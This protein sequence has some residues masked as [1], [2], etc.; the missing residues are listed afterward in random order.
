[1]HRKII[2]AKRYYTEHAGVMDVEVRQERTLARCAPG[3]DGERCRR[4]GYGA[5]ACDR[6]RGPADREGVNYRGK[7]LLRASTKG[8]VLASQTSN[9][10]LSLLQIL[11]VAETATVQ[12]GVINP[13]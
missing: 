1:M 2:V 7:T 13:R 11:E 8:F 3:S 12:D 5:D 4:T 6:A 10:T 9:G